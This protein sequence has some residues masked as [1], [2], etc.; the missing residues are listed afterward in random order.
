[1]TQF[2]NLQIVGFGPAALGL[3]VAADRQNRLT[4]LLDGGVVVHERMTALSEWQSLDYHIEA[5][6]PARDFVSGIR[7]DGCFAACLESPNVRQW[8]GEGTSPPPLKDV[9]AFLRSIA[10]RVVALQEKH[11]R[12]KLQWGSSVQSV[13]WDG[14]TFLA[15]SGDAPPVRS[16]HLV[17]ACGARP[18]HVGAHRP[19]DKEPVPSVN[20]DELLRGRASEA[21]EQALSRGPIAVVGA[22]HS[23]FSAVCFL[24]QRHGNRIPVG[25]I[26][27]AHGGRPIALW[28]P[29]PQSAVGL[30]ASDLIDP[31]TG[32]V[33]KFS[34]LR[35]AARR[36]YLAMREGSERRAELVH[37]PREASLIVGATGYTAN[38]PPITVANGHGIRLDEYRGVVCKDGFTGA[39]MS[40][41]RP[42]EGMFGL[43]IGF[44][45]RRGETFEVGVNYFHGPSA[46][47]VL[48]RIL[49]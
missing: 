26:Q 47:K 39:L 42:I 38:P 17:L 36:M 11:P 28:W 22:S 48:H 32:E 10:S 34:G 6:S 27:V 44:A 49:G 2:A 8:R 43:G 23:A 3:F 31:H 4:S 45:D 35:G 18:S 15:R 12:L 24:L 30:C 20:A 29:S 14:E 9:S 7:P 19:G 41:G 5:N 37:E 1:M 40:D 21:V 25:G 13:H 16:Q 33:N 46:D